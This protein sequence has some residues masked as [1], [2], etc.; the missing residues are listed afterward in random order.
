MPEIT[1][2]LAENETGDSVVFELLSVAGS[3]ASAIVRHRRLGR[4]LGD[5]SATAPSQDPEPG[6]RITVDGLENGVAYE[7]YPAALDGEGNEG[8]PGNV[9]RAVVYDSDLMS[10]LR[11]CIESALL[12][13]LPEQN[14]QGGGLRQWKTDPDHPVAYVLESGMRRE[15]AANCAEF[16]VCSFRVA[17][18]SEDVDVGRRLARLNA[19]ASDLSGR[20]S[21]DLS[22]FSSVDDY[23]DTVV[24]SVTYAQGVPRSPAGPVAAEA[25][26]EMECWISI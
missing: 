16:T 11:G 26:L 18:R 25:A 5:W 17:L 3:P 9:I 20:L 6:T 19:V 1:M 14:I 2:K 23:Y 12:W 10:R 22:L 24:K 4:V 8:L 7:F 13:W 21:D 15:W